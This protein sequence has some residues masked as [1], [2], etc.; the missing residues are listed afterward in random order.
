LILESETPDGAHCLKVKL[1]HIP[2]AVWMSD[3]DSK[4]GDDQI[5]Q[6]FSEGGEG[7]AFLEAVDSQIEAGNFKPFKLT[8]P[9]E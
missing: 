1:S 7:M 2:R 6:D 3:R 5:E 4:N 8:G 9:R